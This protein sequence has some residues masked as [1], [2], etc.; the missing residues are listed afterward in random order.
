[1][2]PRKRDTARPAREIA[3]EAYHLIRAAGAPALATY[4]LGTVPFWLGFIYFANTLELHPNAPALLP[5]M[6]LAL[7]ALWAWMKLWQARFAHLL[8]ATLHGEVP[9]TW[10]LQNA[11]HTATRQTVL[12]A[13]AIVV[14]PICALLVFPLVRALSYYLNLT[15]L[16]RDAGQ[17]IPELH[18][19]AQ[20][21]AERWSAQALVLHWL[22][23]PT[24]VLMGLY[25]V[26][27]SPAI[28][29]W[30]GVPPSAITYSYLFLLVMATF[31]LA[32][33]GFF[34]SINLLA[35]VSLLAVLLKALL[36][37]ETLL[38]L[39]PQL[40]GSRTFLTIWIALLYCAMDPALKTAY[41]LRCFYGSALAN[42]DDI[43]AALR[44]IA[45]QT[46]AALLLFG[47][48]CLLSFA[49]HA[50]AP[51][52]PPA[53]T[54]VEHDRLNQAIQ[55][56]I[57][58]SNYQ[59]R[60]PREVFNESPEGERAVPGLIERAATWVYETTKAV[61]N[62]IEERLKRLFEG[63]DEEQSSQAAGMSGNSLGKVGALVELLVVLMGIVL[64]ACVC[65]F[66]FRQWR[67]ARTEGEELRM[68]AT[69]ETVQI[70]DESTDATA[71]PEEAWRKMAAE[72]HGRG[73]YRLAMRA[74]YLALLA[75]LADRNLITVRRHKTNLAYLRELATH[76]K[77]D[78]AALAAFRHG[79]VAYESV[80]YGE[81][82]ATPEGYQVLLGVHDT[83]RRP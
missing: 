13:S 65:I 67:L 52:T 54:A 43:R 6:A 11:L 69:P 55:G 44:R 66:V 81:H 34:L 24:L 58:K 63:G 72:F 31:L 80:W 51:A 70:E 16:D 41:V 71:L 77:R 25:G 33:L 45:R 36:D 82:M 60:L 22:L 8:R 29:E 32:P 3:E 56:E 68:L 28:A 2:K 4:F 27:F 1:M 73:E 76:L 64:F 23:S 10:R 48:T 50:Q 62:W 14:L 9:S 46:S 26:W 47:A 61:I 83:V 74:V 40:I 20:H 53:Q 38:S 7:T 37:I 12:H 5:W 19:A 59:W 42:G 17:G 79:T 35:T 57:Q 78:H 15:A 21:E 39:L 75:T 18:R 49:A 30:M